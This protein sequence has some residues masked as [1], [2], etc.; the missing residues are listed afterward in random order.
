MKGFFQ[1][2]YCS[3]FVLSS[4]VFRELHSN[5]WFV[6]SSDKK[7]VKD[8]YAILQ[9]VASEFLHFKFHAL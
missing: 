5:S 4:K 3:T 9:L 6:F 7:L 1:V 8:V 2:R